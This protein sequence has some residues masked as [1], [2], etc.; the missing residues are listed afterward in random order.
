MLYSAYYLGRP[1][2]TAKLLADG[3]KMLQSISIDN[4]PFD[5][6]LEKKLEL[7]LL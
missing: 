4:C 7:A 3:I 2:E 5:A 6:R 1:E